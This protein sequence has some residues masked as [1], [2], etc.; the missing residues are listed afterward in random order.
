MGER[1]LH[2]DLPAPYVSPWSLLA[3]DLGAV[4]ASQRLAI[5][6]LWRR[7]RQGLLPLPLFWPSSAAALFW[8][9]LLGLLLAAL[10]L[11]SR[12]PSPRMPSTAVEQ[13]A[14]EQI[15]NEQIANEQLDGVGAAAGMS[16][17]GP[18]GVQGEDPVT[19]PLPAATS[20]EDDPDRSQD[21]GDG[22]GEE[23]LPPPPPSHLDPFA[24]RDPGALLGDARV[25]EDS[26]LLVLVLPRGWRGEPPEERQRLAQL[27]RDRALDLGYER[28]VLEDGEARQLAHS[29]RVGSGMILLASPQPADVR[30]S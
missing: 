25:E 14:V 17:P 20:L 5:W 7:N 4:L 26:R 12:L 9:L 15:A 16:L 19:V 18:N 1:D 3:R 24:D 6:S 8:P 27:W 22:D 21:Q 11:W 23:E 13:P 10:L 29:A 28:L 30:G 2:R